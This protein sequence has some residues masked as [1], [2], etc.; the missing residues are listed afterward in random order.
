MS[1]NS[2]FLSKINEATGLAFTVSEL[3]LIFSMQNNEQN[4]QYKEDLRTAVL[5]YQDTMEHEGMMAEKAIPVWEEVNKRIAL[6]SSWA[7]MAK[8][9]K[10]GFFGR[11]E[12]PFVKRMM[13][14]DLLSPDCDLVK[15]GKLDT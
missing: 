13:L 8:P 4:E 5:I 3:E 12:I 6:W 11:K 7:D 1:N 14:R 15:S 2:A 10:K 9:V